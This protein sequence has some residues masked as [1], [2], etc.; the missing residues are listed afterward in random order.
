VAATWLVGSGF[1]H[2]GH[3]NMDVPSLLGATLAGDVAREFARR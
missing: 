3:P 2:Y 1:R